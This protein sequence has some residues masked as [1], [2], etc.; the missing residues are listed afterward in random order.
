MR[1]LVFV[2]L[3]VASLISAGCINGNQNNVATPS[4]ISSSSSLQ[5][6]PERT[7]INE[8]KTM[9]DNGISCAISIDK[10]EFDPNT[11][12]NP[13]SARLLNVYAT[14]VNTGSQAVGLVCFTTITD[15]AGVSVTGMGMGNNDLLYPQNKASLHDRI[16]IYNQQYSAISSKNS[17]LGVSCMSSAPIA[18]P[19]TN[20]LKTSWDLTPS[21]FH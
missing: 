5:N 14:L 18:K 17:K 1:N 12:T 6:T 15:Y 16:L 8:Q 10:L 3:I 19:Y 21:D 9:E 11:Q 2:A 7:G 13:N 20:N 4:P